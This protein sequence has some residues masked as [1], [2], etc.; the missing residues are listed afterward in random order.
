[1]QELILYWQPIL[2][3]ERGTTVG[4]EALA[5]WEHGGEP[6]PPAAF[7]PSLLGSELELPWLRLQLRQVRHKLAELPRQQWVSFNLSEYA[8]EWPDLPGLLLEEI[9]DTD[10]LLI[11]VSE[12]LLLG[13]EGVAALNLRRLSEQTK[14]LAIDDFGTGYSSF[15]RLLGVTAGL[16]RFL[17][18]DAQI[19]IGCSQNLIQQAIIH[20]LVS[21]AEEL[22]LNLIAEGVESEADR[23]WVR[24]AGV[25][26]GQGYLLGRPSRETPISF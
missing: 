18:L 15:L 3:L 6:V 1:M 26:Y 19:V 25:R 5:R 12:N 24:R 9:W 16:F 21:L 10:R 4:Y 23:D 14:G 11:E 17:K 20:C 2:D 8:F 7:L 13:A 22:H